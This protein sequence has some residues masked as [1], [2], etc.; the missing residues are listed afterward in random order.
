[1]VTPLIIILSLIPS[2]FPQSSDLLDTTA[3]VFNLK[4]DITIL[5][6]TELT[7]G[8]SATGLTSITGV[9]QNNS[10]EN[11]ENMKVNVSLYDSENKILR[12]TSRFISGPFTIYEPNSTERFSFLMSVESFDH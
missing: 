7:I 3:D 4:P 2:S 9:L 6:V 10:T 5:N 11:V 8:D 12:D 1:M